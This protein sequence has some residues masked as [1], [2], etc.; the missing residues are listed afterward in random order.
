MNVLRGLAESLDLGRSAACLL[1]ALVFVRVILAV[2][3]CGRRRLQR[4]GTISQ[5]PSLREDVGDWLDAGLVAV[6][7]ML[8]VVR[9]FIADVV[10]VT[11][12]QMAPTLHGSST[13]QI[14]GPSDRVVVN[15]YLHHYRPLG[16]G[17]LVTY[18]AADESPEGKGLVTKRLIGLPGDVVEV[19]REGRL[20]VNGAVQPEPYLRPGQTAVLPR[21]EVPA[22]NYLVLGD[23]RGP[24][25]DRPGRPVAGFVPVGV[26]R[27]KAVAVCWPLDRI[28]LLR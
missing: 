4:R 18:R 26:I 17:D 15:K 5:R 12:N 7:L 16:R 2:S 27:G 23:N 9:P 1:G 21:Q 6:V 22:G 28:R 24:A 8:F 14:D 10:T 20:L 13:P 25:R 19:D 3:L 11:S